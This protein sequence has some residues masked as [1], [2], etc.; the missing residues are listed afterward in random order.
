MDVAVGKPSRRLKGSAPGGGG[1]SYHIFPN[2]VQMARL[3]GSTGKERFQGK[4][5]SFDVVN[6]ID[7]QQ[8]DNAINNA[9]KAIVSRWDFRNT[10]TEIELNKKENS[11]HIV[12]EDEMKMR[13]I[14]ESIESALFKV[15]IDPKAV[16]Y[17]T[18]QATSNTMVKMDA[19]IIEGIEQEIAKKIV[20]LIKD[21]KL[22]VQ[23]AI[24]G[25]Q[26]RV[27]AKS[28]DDLQEV[29]SLLKSSDLE[30]PLQF[31]NMKR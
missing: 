27:T 8:V 25:D 2:V 30:V 31:V 24:Q 17:G 4:M 7:H 9:R 11:I 6:K 20:K 22:K 10:K 18:V 13:A 28:I 5:P 1:V 14:E 3:I 26:V 16:T 19:K 23:S 21:T 15:G 12:T 29:I